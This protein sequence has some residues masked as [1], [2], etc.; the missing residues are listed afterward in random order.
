MIY[1]TDDPA[2]AR[3]FNF[4]ESLPDSDCKVWTGTLDRNGYGQFSY[5]S[6]KVSAH[7]FIFVMLKNNGDWLDKSIVVRHTCDN[8]KCTEISHLVSGSFSDNLNDAYERGL[9]VKKS[10]LPYC[11]NGHER[12]D[13]NVSWSSDGYMRCKACARESTRRKRERLKVA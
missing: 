9:R 3:F 6:K 7:R 11:K 2:I 4:V 12:K 5:N 10:E 13:N 1:E 8:K